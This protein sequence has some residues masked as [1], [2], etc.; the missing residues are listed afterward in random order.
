[1]LLAHHLMQVC[2]YT[3]LALGKSEL[4]SKGYAE[5]LKPRLEVAPSGSS[6]PEAC[7][8]A[9]KAKKGCN[10]YQYHDPDHDRDGTC[11]LV[12]NTKSKNCFLLSSVQE[13]PSMKRAQAAAEP[14]KKWHNSDKPMYV[15]KCFTGSKYLQDMGW[16][17]DLDPMPLPA[18][19]K[20]C[21]E[22]E[23][24][25]GIS[26]FPQG[27]TV[28]EQLIA[29]SKISKW[30]DA[31]DCAK[32]HCQTSEDW[33]YK[34]E[35]IKSLESSW[36]V[37]PSCPKCANK[38][39]VTGAEDTVTKAMANNSHGRCLE[40]KIKVN[41]C[42]LCYR[43]VSNCHLHGAGTDCT[44]LKVDAPEGGVFLRPGRVCPTLAVRGP[45]AQLGR[46][47]QANFSVFSEPM[48][49]QTCEVPKP[50]LMT[51]VVTG[52]HAQHFCKA[53]LDGSCDEHDN[54]VCHGSSKPCARAIMGGVIER[55]HPDYDDFQ[56]GDFEGQC[57]QHMAA[58]M[59]VK[60]LLTD[61]G[62]NPVI[63]EMCKGVG[64]LAVNEGGH[65]VTE[66]D[67]CK[68]A[69]HIIP[70][71]MLAESFN[72]VMI[73][74][75][76]LLGEL[77]AWM[78]KNEDANVDKMAEMLLS[79]ADRISESTGLGMPGGP[80]VA[81][82]FGMYQCYAD[83][84]TS[85]S[86]HRGREFAACEVE[87]TM[88]LVVYLAIST[89]NAGAMFAT[90][91]E[92]NPGLQA[93]RQTI[94]KTSDFA[95]RVG[96][97]SKKIENL[98]KKV[99]DKTEGKVEMPD[100]AK[101]GLDETQSCADNAVK[102][103]GVVDNLLSGPEGLIVGLTGALISEMVNRALDMDKWAESQ[104][105]L[106]WMY[107][108][109]NNNA[110]EAAKKMLVKHLGE[111]NDHIVK[112][113]LIAQTEIK[114]TLTGMTKDLMEQAKRKVNAVTDY[115]H[116]REETSF[117]V[118]L[119]H[120]FQVDVQFRDAHFTEC[121]VRNAAEQFLHLVK[122]PDYAAIF[123]DNPVCGDSIRDLTCLTAIPPA[124]PCI[125]LTSCKI[126][127][128]NVNSC[129]ENLG[130]KPPFDCKV[131]CAC[132]HK[133]F[134]EL[135]DE[136]KELG[137]E[138]S[139]C[140][141]ACY[142]D[143]KALETNVTKW[144]KR[145]QDKWWTMPDNAKWLKT[146]CHIVEC[147]TKEDTDAAKA[148]AKGYTMSDSIEASSIPMTECTEKCEKNTGARK[149][150]FCKQRRPKRRLAMQQ[151]WELFARPQPTAKSH[152]DSPAKS[153]A[154]ASELRTDPAPL[155]AGVDVFFARGSMAVFTFAATLFI[156]R[157]HQRHAAHAPGPY[158][159]QEDEEEQEP[160]EELE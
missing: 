120:T 54:C 76:S 101:F 28:A 36:L 149:D 43:V 140:K 105:H 75:M 111:A 122:K 33:G 136:L 7:A 62:T 32:A 80:I 147:K 8:V 109:S 18:C 19:Q 67:F 98:A 79:L 13:D 108:A 92:S 15:G 160:E 91:M 38:H 130:L 113:L 57:I 59:H 107:G 123:A 117:C 5:T 82:V 17:K 112:I 49:Y 119:G 45:P 35:Y 42:T 65:C 66:K 55:S 74:V 71:M 115:P 104:P 46:W 96:E 6:N 29:S 39:C 139:K 124:H 2:I 89:T 16:A 58:F 37:P 157:L 52:K 77:R 94:A 116:L 85:D 155:V 69:K 148:L 70:P 51:N 23:D 63:R 61:P 9:C 103:L 114:A 159:A 153:L 128:R 134:N 83:M 27:G 135:D 72:A 100:A 146:V 87:A 34:P 90:A 133:C 81:K 129:A 152:K 150:D 68:I 154:D 20:Q 141:E 84:V 78:K 31:L 40:E 41:A 127:C 44:V 106:D 25:V 143:P 102:I 47:E 125:H 126:A 142:R 73:L 97:E 48:R 110:H 60:T 24:C 21:E 50:R 1:M 158:L 93:T 145:L 99:E 156:V 53:H 95:G 10:D 131:E 138:A 4:C 151:K 132:M 144:D 12:L 26:H 22:D 14:R 137:E 56:Y 88:H 30:Q 11:Y 3:L 64:A 86:K 118:G 121:R